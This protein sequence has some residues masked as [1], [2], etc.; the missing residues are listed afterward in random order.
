MGWSS[1]INKVPHPVR[2]RLL[3]PGPVNTKFKFVADMAPREKV[4]TEFIKEVR[5][6]LLEIYKLSNKTHTAILLHGSGTACN[7][8]VMRMFPKKTQYD[9]LSNGVYGNRFMEIAEYLPLNP[10]FFYYDAKKKLRLDKKHK[11]G[12]IVSMVHHETGTGIKNDIEEILDYYPKETLSHVDAISTFGGVPFDIEKHNVD[13]FVG[14]GN[15]C[16]H[17]FAGISFVIA[18][19]KT[20]ESLKKNKS[21]LTL[22]LYEEWK[23]MEETNQF[24]FTPPIQILNYLNLSVRDII[25]GGEGGIKGKYDKYKRLNK[26]ARDILDPKLINVIDPKETD[27]LM[28]LYKHPNPDF[29]FQELKENMRKLNIILQDSV[30]FSNNLI[31][32]GNIGEWTEE[33]FATTLNL[34][35]NKLKL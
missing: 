7:E 5:T 4:S 2:K 31:R 27:Y 6:N 30:I 33:E 20:L 15:K 14:A 12:K 29:D 13:F 19:K 24:R 32:I 25:Y 1:V 21:S 18:K 11:C 22:N 28:T 16:L 23:Y 34:L 35:V 10:N 8:S 26:I 9:I 17:S 3:I